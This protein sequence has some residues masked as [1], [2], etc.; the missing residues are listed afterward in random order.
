MNYANLGQS[1][2]KASR[3]G[4]GCMPLTGVY[5][6]ATIDDG[7]KALL[8]AVD[9]GINFFDTADVYG[10]GENERLVGTMLRPFR[11]KVIIATKGGA[12]RDKDGKPT[13]DGSPAY[14]RKACDASLQRLGIESIDL[15]YLH[16][17][18]PK[19]PIEDSVGELSR[20][21]TEG[22]IR[23][24]G[25]SEVNAQ[26]LQQ[27]HSV[28]MIAAL[29]TEYSLSCRFAEEDI[30]PACEALGVSF[31]AYSPLGRGLLTR[32]L[33]DGVQFADDDM[34]R[35][36]PRFQ[37]LNIR[38]NLETTAKLKEIAADLGLMPAQLALAWALSHASRPFVIPG[39]RNAARV[40]GNAHAANI[41]LPKSV[42]NE[43]DVLFSVGVIHGER[44]T[45]HM[46][47]R[48]G[49]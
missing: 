2:L 30:M 38:R 48:T 49:L 46:L 4:F 7:A 42:L 12:T 1:A 3:V 20:L 31:I 43:L 18:D 40:V 33:G 36:I 16:R 22:K 39:T 34:R 5:G 29:Q 37:D 35:N 9:A 19:V 44:H 21:V 23:E 26:T 41:A 45:S 14:L 25:L 8:A 6:A 15:Y 11:N 10:N 17:V 27:A 32:D 13:N 28:H 24:I 47:S